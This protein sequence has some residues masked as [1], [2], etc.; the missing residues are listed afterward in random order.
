[1]VSRPLLRGKGLVIKGP[2]GGAVDIV[3]AVNRI[4]SRSRMGVRSAYVDA[5]F[6]QRSG[7]QVVYWG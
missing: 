1:M 3:I 6:A 4:G 2:A 7:L 5:H